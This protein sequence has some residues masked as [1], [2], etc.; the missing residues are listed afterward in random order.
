M[1]TQVENT[2]LKQQLPLYETTVTS[3]IDDPTVQSCKP[4]T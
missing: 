2:L 3:L 1:S 4:A